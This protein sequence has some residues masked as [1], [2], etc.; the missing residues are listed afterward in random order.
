MKIVFLSVYIPMM[1]EHFSKI[2]DQ[3]RRKLSELLKASSP[4]QTNKQERG[5][6]LI[7]VAGC[8]GM[9]CAVNCDKGS[10]SEFLIMQNTLDC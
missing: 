10:S 4:F 2:A 3:S 7:S 1:G 6:S 8:G 9:T 5:R